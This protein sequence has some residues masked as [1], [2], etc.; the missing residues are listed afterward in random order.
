MFKELCPS[1][2]RNI[3]N[4]FQM[5]I[6]VRPLAALDRADVTG[7]RLAVVVNDPN[8]VLEVGVVAELLSALFALELLDLVVD[9]LDVKLQVVSGRVLP[10]A[11]VAGKLLL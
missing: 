7:K 11:E 8:V 10:G 6:Q 4:L 1:N 9:H 5:G 2:P 3:V